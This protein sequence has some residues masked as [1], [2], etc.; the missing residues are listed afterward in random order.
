VD[1]R[2]A[3]IEDNLVLR[4]SE[5]GILIEISYG[6]TVRNNRLAENG[7]DGGWL[8][9][10]QILI[11][12]S[13]DSKVYGNIVDVAPGYGKGISI[14]QQNRGSGPYGLRESRNNQVYNNQIVYR[15]DTASQ[16]IFNAL[17]GAAQ[18]IGNNGTFT[19]NRFYNNQY[20]WPS[21]ISQNRFTWNNRYVDLATFQAA[22]GDSGSTYSNTIPTLN[23]NWNGGNRLPSPT[24]V[25]PPT[26][27]TGN[28]LQG[29]YF[30]NLNFTAPVFTRTDLTVNFN[31]GSGSPSSSMGADTFSVRWTGQVQPLYSE[32]YTFH[33]TAD[34]GIRLW[35]DGKQVINHF[36][37]QPPTERS[38]SITLEAGKKYDIRMEYYENGGGAVAQLAWSSPSQTKQIIPQSQLYSPTTPPSITPTVFR[39]E[40][41]AM[42]Q[43]TGY[44]METIG[45]ASGGRAL[46]LGGRSSN[47]V[48][49]ASFVFRGGTGSY[50]IFLGTFDETDGISRFQVTRNGNNVGSIALDQQLG[51]A[52]PDATTRVRRQV[53]SRV[54]L[55]QGDTIRIQGFENGA[56]F[57]RFDFIELVQ[58]P[59][60]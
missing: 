41:E 25:T 12:S 39:I 54:Q 23:W 44:W 59:Q 22:N 33:V 21:G 5:E 24:P 7:K 49:S 3:V 26:L 11:S 51:S 28:G 32:T 35:V 40:G 47:E 27:A 9:G 45:A 53:A 34:D 10:S 37:D 60:I 52:A 1:D 14:I 19:N 38:G 6:N 15:G 4:N 36:V 13:A 48:G 46:S 43:I 55:G 17:S 50:D 18:D 8:Y 30:N 16:D 57:A 31:W 29:E 20:Y 58:A 42:D 2:G 56:E